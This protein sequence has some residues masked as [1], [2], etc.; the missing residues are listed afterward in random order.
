M[1]TFIHV[2]DVFSMSFNKRFNTRVH[3]VKLMFL[4]LMISKT[5]Q[6]EL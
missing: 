4:E 3:T 1:H 2:V 6:S 5:P